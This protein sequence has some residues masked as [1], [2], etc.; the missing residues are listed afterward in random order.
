MNNPWLKKDVEENMENLI[1]N[2]GKS[3]W[4]DNEKQDMEKQM[5]NWTKSWSPA[6]T[7]KEPTLTY[8]NG[9]LAEEPIVLPRD[10]ELTKKDMR[11]LKTAR[12]LAGIEPVGD[13]AIADLVQKYMPSRKIIFKNDT[14]YV[15]GVKTNITY[16]KIAKEIAEK[17]K[18][19]F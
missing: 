17:L 6:T 8:E 12:K 4:I 9:Y 1:K 11:E 16:A 3:D 5:E 2:S 10:S 18:E 14:L 13:F 19:V 7:C 15:D